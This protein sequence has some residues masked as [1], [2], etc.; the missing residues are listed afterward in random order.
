MSE[1]TMNA[2]ALKVR[3]QALRPTAKVSRTDIEILLKAVAEGDF[4]WVYKTRLYINWG[5][6]FCELLSM[7]HEDD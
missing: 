2:Q 6:A 5:G 4:S 7:I 3:I 1:I